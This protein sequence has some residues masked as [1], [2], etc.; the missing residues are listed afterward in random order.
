MPFL[1]FQFDSSPVFPQSIDFP[2]QNNDLTSFQAPNSTIIHTG[3]GIDTPRRSNDKSLGSE[4]ND[5]YDFVGT[6]AFSETNNTWELLAWG[7]DTCSDGY[8]VI[9]ETPVAANGAPAGL[10]IESR[11]DSG[12][13]SDTLNELFTAL[14][15]LN[16]QALSSLVSET[17]PLVQNGARDGMPPVA[18]DAACVNNTSS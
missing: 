13:S 14:R 12:P 10:D 11:T 18:C 15:K 4:W 6:G 7:Y 1:N 8:M 17:V 3:F 16:N 2:G 9:Y 5:V